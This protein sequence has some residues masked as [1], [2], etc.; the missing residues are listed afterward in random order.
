MGVDAP[1]GAIWD[2]ARDQ[3][4]TIMTKD[5]D[6]ATWVAARRAGPQVV[7]IRLG[8]TTTRTLLA[9]LSPRWAMVETRLREG[10]HLVELR[11]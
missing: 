1:D 4:R 8:N 6:F 5:R 3:A 7:W 9:W 2:V 10:V 11:A